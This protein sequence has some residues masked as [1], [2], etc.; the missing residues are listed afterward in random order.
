[1]LGEIAVKDSDV[2]MLTLGAVKLGRETEGPEK[3]GNEKE[4]NEKEG[5]EMEGPLKLLVLLALLPEPE[6][7]F[8]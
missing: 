7:D 2:S 5:R 8:E 1:M 6:L 4:G 3:E